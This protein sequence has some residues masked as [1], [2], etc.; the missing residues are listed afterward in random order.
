MRKFT[1]SLLLFLPVFLAAQHEFAP[2]GATWYYEDS[3]WLT[4][5]NI[6]KL[7]VIGIDTIQGHACKRIEGAWGCSDCYPV[8][9]VYE[10][11]G[12]VYRFIDS[13]FSLFID[14]KAQP[15]ES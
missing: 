4:Q 3:G 6:L 8:L 12:K 2:L 13:T 9:H 15:G 5:P 14:F 11:N 10:D 1:I 7:E